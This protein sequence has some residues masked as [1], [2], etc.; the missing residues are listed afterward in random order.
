MGKGR[1]EPTLCTSMTMTAREPGVRVDAGTSASYS[2]EPNSCAFPVPKRRTM[3]GAPTK[4]LNKMVIRP[5]SRRCAMVSLP[6]H[7]CESR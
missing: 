6:V 3:R 4:A 5:F 1:T 2:A 7:S